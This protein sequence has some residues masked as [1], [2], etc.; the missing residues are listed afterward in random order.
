MCVNPGQ[1]GTGADD[2]PVV[3]HIV[4]IDLV[5]SMEVASRDDVFAKLVGQQVPRQRHLH[6]RL[7]M[8]LARDNVNLAGV[9]YR[10]VAGSLDVDPV[11][12]HETSSVGSAGTARDCRDD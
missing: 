9:P 11:V 12:I 1:P 2:W 10:T 7:L 4:R 6:H 3:D 5:E 8:A